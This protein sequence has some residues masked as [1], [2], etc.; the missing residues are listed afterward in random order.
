MQSLLIFNCIVTI[1][2]LVVML[3]DYYGKKHKN[4]EKEVNDDG[5]DSRG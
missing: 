4:N 3:K 2:H 5:K 1:C